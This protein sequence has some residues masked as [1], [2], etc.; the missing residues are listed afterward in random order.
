MRFPIII[1][2][3]LTL[4]AC[5]SQPETRELDI[6]TSIAKNWQ[7]ANI[8][9]MIKVWGDPRTLNQESPMAGAGTANWAHFAGG[10]A[11]GGPA[12]QR[13]RCE[14]TVSFDAQGIITTIDVISQNCKPDRR[15]NMETIRRE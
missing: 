4:V 12:V 13:M 5:T 2:L 10:G 7:G 3:S 15:S 6:F 9:E 8:N 1:S 14:A 11:V